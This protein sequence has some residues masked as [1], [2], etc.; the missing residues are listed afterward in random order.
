MGFSAE[1]PAET[2]ALGMT[3]LQAMYAFVP[4]VIGLLAALS[5]K[6]YPLTEARHA[7]IRQQLEE[8]DATLPPPIPEDVA[9]VSPVISPA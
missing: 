8:R 2:T 5:M 3:S 7:E 4:G 9:V 6:G 1:N